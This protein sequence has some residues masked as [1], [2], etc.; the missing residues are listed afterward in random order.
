MTEPET[1]PMATPRVAAGALFFDDAGRILLVRPTY[2]NHWDIPGGYVEPGESPR[3]A[4]VREIH[5][6]LGL[7]IDVGP[8]LV[9]DWAPAP[10]EGDKILF[11][12]H[13]SRNYKLKPEDIHFN[14]GEISDL[15]WVSDADL[16]SH[17]PDRLARRIRTSFKAHAANTAIYAENGE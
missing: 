7:V 9:V 14:D 16:D 15:S 11:V 4:C 1:P 5:E 6:E 17:V 12:F 8:L 10:T 3:A 2:K 13:G